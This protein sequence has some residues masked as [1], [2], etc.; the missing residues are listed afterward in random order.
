[1]AL[2]E[3]YFDAIH[4]DVVKRKYY[5]A[6]K[7]EAVFADIRRQALELTAENERLRAQ[8][9]Q[10]DGRKEE[11][12]DAVISAQMLYREILNKA[13]A[14]A[15]QILAQADEQARQTLSQAEDQAGKLVAQA[16]R[17]AEELAR[18]RQ[19]QEDYASH[20]VE[21]VISR[22]R[23]MHER[24]IEELNAELRDFL[25]GLMPPESEAESGDESGEDPMQQDLAEKV[26]RI[27]D[28]LRDLEDDDWVKKEW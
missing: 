8:L 3:A 4:I 21:A 9:G 22:L 17:E 18:E 19:R 14:R 15:E 27:A 16:R 10:L 7:V 26:S 28:N 23:Q 5:N 12:G 25:A 20:K 11:I 6:N 1:M 13:N 24:S 2:D